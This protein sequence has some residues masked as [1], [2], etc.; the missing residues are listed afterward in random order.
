MFSQYW[1]YFNTEW[2]V[3]IHAL[4]C[5]LVV[6][7]WQWLLCFTGVWG[8]SE[9]VGSFECCGV[10][11]FWQTETGKPQEAT[12][13]AHEPAAAIPR[14]LPDCMQTTS[15]GTLGKRYIY[16]M[17]AERKLPMHFVTAVHSIYIKSVNSLNSF[18]K[19]SSFNVDKCNAFLL[20]W[21]LD[22]HQ[23]LKGKDT[24]AYGSNLCCHQP[25]SLLYDYLNLFFESE[26]FMDMKPFLV[27]LLFNIYSL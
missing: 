7:E 22:F 9:A 10:H 24:E 13:S 1:A 15:A 5:L 16:D 6:T 20:I 17:V 18:C 2:L 19:L 14:G 26:D 4:A 3:L 27:L 8:F 21:W 25:N 12:D 11:K 23:V